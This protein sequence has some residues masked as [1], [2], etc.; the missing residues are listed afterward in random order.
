[1]TA[2]LGPTPKD[3]IAQLQP[4]VEIGVAEFIVG[5]EDLAT[6]EQFAA[7]VVPAFR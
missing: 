4:F 5:F 3:A 2:P 6:A 7:E 1:M